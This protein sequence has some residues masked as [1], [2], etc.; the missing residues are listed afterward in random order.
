MRINQL[1]IKGMLLEKIMINKILIIIF[2]LVIY[3]MANFPTG[4]PMHF[5]N[6]SANPIPS[7]PSNLGEW[8]NNLR[9]FT[10][11]IHSENCGKDFGGAD[12]QWTRH[13]VPNAGSVK[14]PIKLMEYVNAPRARII[15]EQFSLNIAGTN[16]T[17]LNPVELAYASGG[18]TIAVPPYTTPLAVLPGTSLCVRCPQALQRNTW[19]NSQPRSKALEKFPTIIAPFN[20]QNAS[21]PPAQEGTPTDIIMMCPLNSCAEDSMETQAGGAE[22]RAGWKW[23]WQQQFNIHDLGAECDSTFLNNGSLEINITDNVGRPFCMFDP[24]NIT[25]EN[26][27]NIQWSFKFSI[28]YESQEEE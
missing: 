17:I 3:K 28:V 23:N 7:M 16:A 18:G 12:F 24:V 9:R 5:V 26:N 25:D 20:S 2:Y 22:N 13:S 10:V 21:Y 4:N 11:I 6:A 27:T 1:L 19:E 8:G 14:I 15:P